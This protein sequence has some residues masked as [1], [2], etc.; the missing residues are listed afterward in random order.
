MSFNLIAEKWIPVVSKDWQRQEVSLVEL[1]QTWEEWREI[2]AENPPTT[3][4]LYRFL[5]AILHRTYQGPTDVDHWLEIKE[6]NGKKVIAYLQK[7]ADC[8]DLL[9]PERPFM[10]DIELLKIKKPT[11]IYVACEM[12]ADNQPTLFSHKHQWSNY[13]VSLSVASR[14]LIR[15]QSFDPTSTRASYPSMPKNDRSATNTPTVNAVN[16][17]VQG[18][19]LKDTLLLNLVR[20]DPEAEEPSVVQGEDLP[21]WEKG[22]TGLPKKSIP[23]GYIHYLTYPWRRLLLFPKGNEV[24]ELAITMGDSLPEN[25]SP[26]QWECHIPYKQVAKKVAKKTEPLHLSLERQLWRDAD[27]LLQ[28]TEISNPPRII[29]WLA[30]IYEGEHLYFQVFG[31]SADKAKPLRWVVEQLSVPSK[32]MTD[33]K[34]WEALKIAIAFAEQHSQIFLSFKGS[35]YFAL[36]EALKGDAA[37]ISKS[38]DGESRYWLNLDRLFPIF[39]DEL[40]ED[41]EV[42]IDGIKRYGQRKLPEWKNHVQNAAQSAFE[43]SISAIRDRRARALGLRSLNHWL[44]K[45]RNDQPDQ[46]STTKKKGAKK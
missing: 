43:E 15:L 2:Q 17:L 27:C 22:Y 42:G 26:S 7:Y 9:H 29:N 45:L 25:I 12:Q 11:P 36:A 38:L 19:M 8:F 34:L 23:T 30:N 32:Y 37:V 20:Y 3:L 5:L 4:A 31:L 21:T 39:L 1:F 16:I 40:A 44:A 6:D 35:P 13:R 41:E 18:K 33:R 14:M 28:S 10:Q 24:M 46:Q